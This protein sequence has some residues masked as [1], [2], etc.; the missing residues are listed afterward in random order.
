MKYFNFFK[1]IMYLEFFNYKAF[2]FGF[3]KSFLNTKSWI[4]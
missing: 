2:D 3:R 1:L 4:H